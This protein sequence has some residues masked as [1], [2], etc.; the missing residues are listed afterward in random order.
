MRADAISSAMPASGDA[1]R[2]CPNFCSG[3]PLARAGSPECVFYID[4]HTIKGA[5]MTIQKPVRPC[6]HTPNENGQWHDLLEHLEG[7]ARRAKEFGDKFGA[8]E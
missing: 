2:G 6:A 1:T 8:G 5:L 4:R 7:V 3:P